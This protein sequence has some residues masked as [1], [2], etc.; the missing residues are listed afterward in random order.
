MTKEYDAELNEN[1]EADL[2]DICE[3]C[4]KRRRKCNSKFIPDWF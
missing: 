2:N 1:L 3:E 4:K